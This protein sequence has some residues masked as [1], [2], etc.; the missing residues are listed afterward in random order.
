[1]YT[2]YW[3]SNQRI[4]SLSRILLPFSDVDEHV[5]YTLSFYMV[6]SI[7]V[8][9]EQQALWLNHSTEFYLH[10]I[11]PR[12]LRV[13]K[14]L[15]PKFRYQHVMSLSTPEIFSSFTYMKHITYKLRIQEKRNSLWT[16]KCFGKIH[17]SAIK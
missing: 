12:W 1:M 10:L 3:R 14:Y 11:S 2:L 8:T 9:E 16:G 13:S 15:I 6:I 7:P 5:A 4:V 17:K